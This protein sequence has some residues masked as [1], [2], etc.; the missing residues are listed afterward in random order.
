VLG[1]SVVHHPV[2]HSCSILYYHQYTIQVGTWCV[3]PCVNKMLQSMCDLKIATFN[4]L[5]AKQQF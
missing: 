1:I 3:V 5:C 4:S 2:A